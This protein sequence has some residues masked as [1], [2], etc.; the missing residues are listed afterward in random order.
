MSDTEVVEAEVVGTSIEQR[1]KQNLAVAPE[2]TI[3]ELVAQV[4]KVQQAMKKVM[5]K[6]EHYG[7][8]PGTQRP[9]LYKPG[10][11]KL[12]LLFRLAPSYDTDKTFHDDGHLTVTA[13][14][15]LVHGPTGIFVAAG[16]GMC[17]T[18]EAKYAYRNAQR[19]CPECGVAAIIKGKREYGGGWLCFKKKEG[20][21]AKFPDG[22]EAIESQ[23]VGRIPNPDVPDSYNTVLKMACKRALI[24]AVLNG[25][26][27]SDIFTQ[28]VEDFKESGSA[29]VPEQSREA[30]PKAAKSAPKDNVP[31]P[32]SPS[33][34]GVAASGEAGSG[35][36]PA[37]RIKTWVG[38]KEP[39]R[40]RVVLAASKVC[41]ADGIAV[42]KEGFTPQQITDLKP[43]LLEKIAAEVGA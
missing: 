24:A 39:R 35:P 9:T 8:I 32:V 29:S 30:E 17:S 13:I 11:E 23:E 10:A 43:E 27:A 19:V 28:D 42:P 15:N 12:M 20:C 6:D 18:K 5:H 34:G 26:A 41:E 21:G 25:T 38:G 40:A 36:D 7:V 22:D 31:E 2:L 14:C 1:P 16:E 4:A 33:Q 3:E 37:T